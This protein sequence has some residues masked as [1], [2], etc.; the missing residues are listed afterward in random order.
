MTETPATMLAQLHS[1]V[2]ADRVLRVSFMAWDPDHDDHPRDIF[3]MRV[4]PADGGFS[5]DPDEALGECMEI[6]AAGNLGE[7]ASPKLRR[8]WMVGELADDIER[9][10]RREPIHA[11]P[12]ALGYRMRLWVRRHRRALRG[13]L[14]AL[15]GVSVVLLSSLAIMVETQRRAEIGRLWC[16][17]YLGRFP[18][19]APAL[20]EATTLDEAPAA[21]ATHA[22]RNVPAR[23]RV[24]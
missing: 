11:R 21:G 18:D 9:F 7:L 5:M 3:E 17:T 1:I 19:K 22:V 12:V 14:A 2:P 4:G 8:M 23:G 10:Q 13:G 6:N 16:E 15:I 20:L 24:F